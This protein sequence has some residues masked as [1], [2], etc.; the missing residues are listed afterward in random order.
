M[1]NIIFKWRL[2]NI[3]LMNLFRS[4]WLICLRKKIPFF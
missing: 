1:M 3:Q 2:H 4:I